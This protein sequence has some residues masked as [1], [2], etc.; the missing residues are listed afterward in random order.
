MPLN[1]NPTDCNECWPE[2]DYEAVLEKVEDKRS[3]A[4]NDM[5]ELTWKVYRSDGRTQQVYDYIVV[6][7]GL[8]KLKGMAR[9][10]GKTAEFDGGTFQADD[11]LDE[12][13]V[14]K[15]IVEKQDG[16]ADKNRI[17]A[18]KP[19]VRSTVGITQAPAAPSRP[20]GGNGPATVPYTPGPA[21]VGG[22]DEDIPF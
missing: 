2:G 20:A 18:Y 12:S 5:Q 21:P 7:A 22:S 14:V 6:P 9:A 10:W 17:V 16:Y 1:Y 4:G 8:F 3:K 11:H 13:L 15:L 19:L